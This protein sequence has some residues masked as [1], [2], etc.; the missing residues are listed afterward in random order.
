MQYYTRC[1]I[2][3]YTLIL[4]ETDAYSVRTY[5]RNTSILDTDIDTEIQKRADISNI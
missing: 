4:I 2:Y 1:H 5:V 3:S